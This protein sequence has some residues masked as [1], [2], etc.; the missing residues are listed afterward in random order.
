MSN[1]DKQFKVA[2]FTHF[3]PSYFSRLSAMLEEKQRKLEM[4]AI[5]VQEQWRS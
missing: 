2:L 5:L 3:H 4:T 1:L